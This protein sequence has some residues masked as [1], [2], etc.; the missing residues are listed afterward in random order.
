MSH[1]SLDL[2]DDV[3]AAVAGLPQGDLAQLA[4]ET[5]LVRVYSLG[6]ISSGRCAEILGMS[7]RRFLDLAGEYGASVFEQPED[8]KAEASRGF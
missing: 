3:A 8:L 4:R 2:P 6:R 1:V 5:L 7:R